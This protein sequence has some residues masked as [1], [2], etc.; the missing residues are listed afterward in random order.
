[1]YTIDSLLTS[2]NIAIKSLNLHIHWR[3]Q[4]NRNDQTK[5]IKSLIVILF[6]IHLI[7]DL[8]LKWLDI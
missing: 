2:S 1:M 4:L 7:R 5:S 8:I 3:L 6:D